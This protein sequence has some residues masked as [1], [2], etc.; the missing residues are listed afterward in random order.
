MQR[1]KVLIY[2]AVLF[3]L[4]V[5]P[6]FGQGTFAIEIDRQL[7]IPCQTDEQIFFRID[8]VTDPSNTRA[9]VC[10]CN[11]LDR[12]EP[13]KIPFRSWMEIDRFP[14]LAT[15]WEAA[16]QWHVDVEA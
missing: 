5:Q 11:F 12:S 1:L 13:I 16:K 14:G 10:A 8:D 4:G 15:N 3:A 7:L 2:V 6:G 9:F